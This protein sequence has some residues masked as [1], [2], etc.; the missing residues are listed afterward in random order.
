MAFVNVVWVETLGSVVAVLLLG[1]PLPHS[2]F[3]A[4][5]L[6]GILVLWEVG[7]LEQHI[8]W[9]SLGILLVVFP[10]KVLIYIRW[11]MAALFDTPVLAAA[12]PAEL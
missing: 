4:V 3:V 2:L 9:V 10:M 8:L 11:R 6:F 5:V 7:P 12:D 1:T